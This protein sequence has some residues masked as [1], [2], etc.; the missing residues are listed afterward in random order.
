[1]RRSRQKNASTTHR[2]SP[3]PAMRRR[4]PEV[5]KCPA[6][7]MLD[8]RR[9][10][11][12]DVMTAYGSGLRASA[13]SRM[14]RGTYNSK[15]YFSVRETLTEGRNCCNTQSQVEACKCTHVL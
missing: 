14:E 12:G 8:P 4:H 13:A 7:S 6:S 3:G 15:A 9:A 1:M 11:R 10:A 5:R 2:N